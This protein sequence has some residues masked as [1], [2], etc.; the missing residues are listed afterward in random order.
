MLDQLESMEDVYLY[1]YESSTDY[2]VYLEVATNSQMT[3]S[4]LQDILFREE[5]MLVQL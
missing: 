5:M 3:E 4:R 2:G 1:L